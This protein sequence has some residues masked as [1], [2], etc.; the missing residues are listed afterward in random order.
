MQ[1]K[2]KRLTNEPF[3]GTVV[4]SDGFTADVYVS[5]DRSIIRYAW[6]GQGGFL[7]SHQLLVDDIERD[8]VPDFG[9]LL[10]VLVDEFLNDPSV[11]PNAI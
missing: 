11:S 6:K 9:R 5:F 4:D 7:N 1:P 3:L 2:F 10:R 8:L